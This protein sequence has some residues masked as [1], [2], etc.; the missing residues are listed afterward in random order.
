MVS[1]ANKRLKDVKL[2]V[3][4]VVTKKL[5]GLG[6]KLGDDI[7]LRAFKQE[8]EMEVWVRPSGKKEYKLYGKFDIAGNS[9]GLGPKLAEGDYQM[10]EGFYTV[11]AGGLNPNSRFHLS[12]NIGYPNSYDRYHKRTGSFIMVHGSNVSV[13]CYAMTDP[14]IEEIYLLVEADLKEGDKKVPFHSYPFRYSRNWEK[15]EGGSKWIPYWKHLEVAYDA[16][17]KSKNPP[18]VSHS[19]GQYIISPQ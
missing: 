11:L 16:F 17:N 1:S 5:D 19:K 13:G 18:K 15:K 8:K 7:Y 4:P 2:R 14:V 3:T 6:A 9:G 12:F 10:P